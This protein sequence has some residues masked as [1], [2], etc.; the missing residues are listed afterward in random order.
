M[1]EPSSKE[2]SLLP[3]VLIPFSGSRQTQE[4]LLEGLKPRF[5][6]LQ[7]GKTELSDDSLNR[8]HTPITTQHPGSPPHRCHSLKTLQGGSGHRCHQEM[9]LY[10][11]ARS[12]N[13]RGR[14]FILQ[15]SPLARLPG[16]SWTPPTPQASLSRTQREPLPTACAA[17]LRH[18]SNHSTAFGSGL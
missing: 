16:Q 18:G 12:N 14:P 15:E 8:S 3:I 13:A 1:L 10:Q 17:T 9:P 4:G 11:E 7:P 6:S 5:Y 2:D